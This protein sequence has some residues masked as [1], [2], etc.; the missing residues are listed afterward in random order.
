MLSK[1]I[2]SI[3]LAC[4]LSCKA[5]AA[6]VQTMQ[7]YP[8]LTEASAYAWKC[9]G[10]PGTPPVVKI[11]EGKDLTCRNSPGT[12][13]AGFGCYGAPSSPCVCSAGEE[14]SG[15]SPIVLVARTPNQPW[16]QTAIVHEYEHRVLRLKTGDP[17][18]YHVGAAWASELVRCAIPN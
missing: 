10:G 13:M 6:T 9:L 5:P 7:A 11:I 4:L 12:Q 3:L 15:Y 16:S 1:I 18:V 17:N 2:G 14:D 8:G